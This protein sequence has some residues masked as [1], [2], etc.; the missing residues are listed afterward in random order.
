MV[1]SAAPT[2]QRAEAKVRYY[3]GGGSL[4][5]T[6]PIID[7]NIENQRRIAG[8]STSNSNFI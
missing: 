1:T 2:I 3:G 4:Q 7:E 8:G 5:E 6:K